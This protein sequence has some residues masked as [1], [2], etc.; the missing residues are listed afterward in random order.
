MCLS[1]GHQGEDCIITR[2]CG[3]EGCDRSH[4]RLLHGAPRIYPLKTAVGAYAQ[5]SNS[6]FAGAV[7]KRNTSGTLLPVVPVRLEFRG[8]AV[9]TFA[10]LDQGS[11]LTRVSS[12][13]A[14]ELF[15]DGLVTSM[16]VETVN[17][18]AQQEFRKLP[19]FTFASRDGRSK[20]ELD[21]TY[22]IEFLQ[23]AI[24]TKAPELVRDHRVHP[25]V[26]VST[27]SFVI[28]FITT[29]M[30]TQIRIDQRLH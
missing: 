10:F 17:G 16:I 23:I 5:P 9:N 25:L 21:D 3:H 20:F 12:N 15:L 26:Q 30:P 1:S 13:L 6:H 2:K 19:S 11:E 22:V 8:R 24:K 4:H 18:R 28:V 14:K 7:S 29:L 27:F